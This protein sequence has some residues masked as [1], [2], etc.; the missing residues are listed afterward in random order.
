[1]KNHVPC[2]DLVDRF[3]IER[4][5]V[6]Y[7]AYLDD[8]NWNG[9]VGCFT[10]SAESYYNNDGQRLVGGAG[11]SDWLHRMVVYAATNHTF[12]NAIINIDDDHATAHSR[13]IATLL[14]GEH[15]R[16]RV[17][18]RGIDYQDELV[19]VDN[20]WLICKR[21]HQPVWQYDAPSTALDLY[22]K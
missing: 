19:R 18:V 3:L 5:L 10:G 21:V 2:D 4:V 8:Q 12:S 13:V 22:S 17:Q 7:L 15:G 14:S 6:R 1:M 11:V 9:I 16:G 20:L